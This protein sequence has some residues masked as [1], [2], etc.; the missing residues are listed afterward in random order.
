MIKAWTEA[1]WEGYLWWQG[2]DRKTLRCINSL[3][4]DIKRN[5]FSG[6]GK[7]EPLRGDLPGLWSRCIDAANRLVYSVADNAMTIYF[8][9]DHY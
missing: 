9:K 2:Q 6:T 8:A 1:A 3:I 5:P 4:R 7:P